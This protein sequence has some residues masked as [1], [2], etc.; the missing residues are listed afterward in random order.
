[1][2]ENINDMLSV[3]LLSGFLL[4]M[5]YW[6]INHQLRKRQKKRRTQAGKFYRE[7]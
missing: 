4:G 6:A 3:I 5:I 7:W 2:V 1:M